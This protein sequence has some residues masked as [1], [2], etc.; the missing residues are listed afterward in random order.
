M[1]P[2]KDFNI[3]YMLYK[4]IELCLKYIEICAKALKYQLIIMLRSMN[5]LCVVS[6][7][8]TMMKLAIKNSVKVVNKNVG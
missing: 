2:L 1:N 8:S 6:G 5:K 7:S 4:I 3:I